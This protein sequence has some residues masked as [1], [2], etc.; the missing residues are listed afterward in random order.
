MARRFYWLK[1]GDDFFDSK[2]IKKLRKIAGGDT[3]T[4][5][6]LKMLLRSMK[7]DGK[8]YFE[9]FED[10]FAE[11][12][13][14]DIDEDPDNVRVTVN[15]LLNAGLMQQVGEDEVGLTRLP[16]MV[17]S[18]SE[19]A[20]R[21]RRSRAAKQLALPVNASHCDANVRM[22][23]TEKRSEEKDKDKEGEESREETEEPTVPAETA[24]APFSDIVELYHRICI[25]YPRVR[26]L[27][28]ERR[29]HI[30]ARWKEYDRDIETFRE[31]FEA[32]EASAFLKGQ[33]PRNW[34]AD[35]NWLM[36]SDNMAKVLE[37]KYKERLHAS[38]K[39]S[40]QSMLAWLQEIAAE[41]QAAVYAEG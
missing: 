10:T 26:S 7:D 32:A 18:E 30:A 25:S 16:E 11:E 37:G 39:S 8:F 34:T 27:S 6:Y 13:A 12:I 20:R 41:D 33:N 21:M 14:L 4:V 17:G 28:Q 9:G 36:K 3:F 15:Y 29:K 40:E 19:S 22:S 38:R 31:L 23:D 5:I 2:E 35:F 24:A 1:L